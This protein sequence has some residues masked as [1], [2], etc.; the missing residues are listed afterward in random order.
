MGIDADAPSWARI[1]KAG[2]GAT[3]SVLVTV[4]AASGSTPRKVGA[5]MLVEV[6][7]APPADD[8]ALPHPEGTVGGGAVEIAGIRLAFEAAHCSGT[9]V[10]KVSLGAEL[11]MCCGGTMTLMAQPL[12]DRPTLLV[13]GLGHVGAA[14]VRLA[15]ECGFRVEGIDA[16]ASMRDP[17]EPYCEALHQDFDPE[18]LAALPDGSQVHALVVTHDHDL[19]QQLVEALLRRPFAS[20]QMLGSMRKAIRCRQRLEAH[21]FSAAEIARLRCP[22]GLKISAET[23]AEIAIAVVAD[24]VAQRRG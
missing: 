17:I 4:V 6:Q 2:A 9:L 14:V 20:L 3:P 22:A 7:G 18:T 23:P 24:L 1:A 8:A 10:R 15:S 5:R 19:D 13:L 21:G 16:R 12:I 11:A